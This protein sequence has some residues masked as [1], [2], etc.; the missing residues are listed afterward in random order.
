MIETI[1]LSILCCF[2]NHAHY[3]WLSRRIEK[4][5]AIPLAQNKF[6][7]RCWLSHNKMAKS[8]ENTIR[9][10]AFAFYDTN[11]DQKLSAKETVTAM[12]AVGVN[13]NDQQATQL[14]EKITSEMGGFVNLNQYLDLCGKDKAAGGDSAKDIQMV[15]NFLDEN[16]D[17][18]LEASVLKK[19]FMNFGDKL[20]D[21]EVNALFKENRVPADGRINFELFKRIMIGE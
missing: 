2:P 8:E 19:F 3:E 16:S 10:E 18:I 9:Q 21:E 5:N 1:S 4:A 7:R 11:K 12:R 17:G 20:K 14:T 15:F 13:I 6:I